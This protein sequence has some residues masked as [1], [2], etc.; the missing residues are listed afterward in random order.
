MTPSFDTNRAGKTGTREWSEHSENIGLGCSNGCLYCYARAAALRRKQIG[1]PDE[2]RTEKITRA[3]SL[4]PY[5]QR[6]GVI[7]YPTTHDITPAYLDASIVALRAMLEAGNRVLIVT[8]PRLDCIQR[9]VKELAP[10]KDR[11]LFRFTITTLTHAT[12]TYWEPGAPTPAERMVRRIH[13]WD[14]GFQTSVSVEPLLGGSATGIEIFRAVAPHV[15]EKVWIGKLNDPWRRVQEIDVLP[16]CRR[17]IGAIE[18]AQ[19][20]F[21]MIDLYN[22]LKSSDKIA[23]KDSIRQV[24]DRHIKE[25]K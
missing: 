24:I 5:P 7:M 11:I 3:V 18:K 6:S 23:W 8:K 9:L 21:I 1:N 20:D 17:R 22:A 15:T 10:Y 2:W 14:R 4:G 16:D 13:A 12:S 25:E 19:R